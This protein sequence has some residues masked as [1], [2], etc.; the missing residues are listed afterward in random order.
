MRRSRS[1]LALSKAR[2]RRVEAVVAIHCGDG[3]FRT[4]Y[5]GL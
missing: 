4:T 1:G 2:K 3:G 5:V